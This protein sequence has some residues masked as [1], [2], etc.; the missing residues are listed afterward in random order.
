MK[1]MG[2]FNMKIRKADIMG[3]LIFGFLFICI[4]FPGDPYNVKLVFFFLAC[5]LGIRIFI[6]QMRKGR[7]GYVL[8]M[9]IFYPI[10][11]ASCSFILTGG[12]SEAISGAYPAA[13]LLLVIL[14]RE[15]GIP[16]E[17]YMMLLL[18]VM[19]AATIMIVVLDFIGLISVNGSSFLRDSFYRYG[20]GLMGKSPAY[21]AYYK[22]FFKASPL[23]LVLLPYCF[24]KNK[25]FMAGVTFVALVFSGTRANIFVAAI[26]F[27]FGCFNA[28]SENKDYYKWKLSF[29]IL[30]LAGLAGCLPFIFELV[31]K[32][33]STAGAVSSDAV[34][35]GQYASFM[36]VFSD[37]IK[38][39][40]GM[41]F[42]SEFYDMG[43]MAYS[44]ASEISY[45]DLLRKIGLIWF[46]PFL[47]FI[48]RP[49][50]WKI[51][52]HLKAAY[53]GYLL[54]A[55]TNP[56]LYSSTA[57]V[58]YIYLYTHERKQKGQ[59]LDGQY[60][61]GKR[62]CQGGDWIYSRKHTG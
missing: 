36:F 52:I 48:I 29:G 9:G 5:I 61:K 57:Y 49:F 59:I 6:F 24:E 18:Q 12:A 25:F 8:I 20:M 54:A 28:W 14:V 7:Y 53:M 22:V 11:I 27:L 26:I 3:A 15:Y 46:V 41:G 60:F 2:K 43:R 40:C 13:L 33:M 1:L 32:M 16:Y 31:L 58:L 35:A 34:R 39:I 10:A 21:A 19:A 62:S 4:F 42:G 56:L 51:G 17:K 23:L 44:A 45:F 47:F 30:I 55:T 50:F 38:L 37:S